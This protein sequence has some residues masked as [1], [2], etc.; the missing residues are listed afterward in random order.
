ME[1]ADRNLGLYHQVQNDNA[2]GFSIESS[3]E[4][5]M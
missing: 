4:R 5:S 1:Y 2:A 3:G